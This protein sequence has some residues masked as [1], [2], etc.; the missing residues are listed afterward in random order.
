MI[1]KSN[2]M[3]LLIILIISKADASEISDGEED[4]NNRELDVA[5]KPKK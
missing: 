1:V 3:F 2:W 4:R 5:S